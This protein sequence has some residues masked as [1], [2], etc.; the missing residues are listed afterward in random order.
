[1]G[2]LGPATYAILALLL[3]GLTYYAVKR[4]RKKNPPDGHQTDR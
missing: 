4:R 3:I 2:N 1:M